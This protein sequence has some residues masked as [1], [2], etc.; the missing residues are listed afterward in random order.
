MITDAKWICCTSDIGTI[1]PDFRKTVSFKKNIKNATAYISA[2]GLYNFFIN[3][4]KVG[5]A[6]LAPGWTVLDKRVQY[7]TY[8]ITDFITE[9]TVFSIMCGE[10]WA[11]GRLGTPLRSVNN[12][13][14]D[15]ISVIAEVVVTYE[16]GSV[17]VIHTDDTWQVYTSEILTSGLYD[18]ETVDTTVTPEFVCNASFDDTVTAKLVEQISELVCERERVA[19]K[20]YFITPKGERVIDFG[21]ELAGYVE[22]KIKGKR[23]D[24][25]V[26]THAEVLDK[27]GNF[28]NDNYRSAKNELVYVLSG[29]EDIFKPSFTFQGY[30]YIRLDEFPFDNVDL[31]CFTSVAIY[32]D[33]K[34]TG[35]FRCGYEKLNQLYSNILW[36]QRSNFI[37]IPTDCPQR[38]ERLGWTGDAQVFCRTASI[39]YNT[40]KFF[41]KWLGDVALNQMEDGAVPGVIPSIKYL[42]NGGRTI[43]AGWGDVATIAPWEIYLAYGNKEM[44]R[45]QYDMMKKWVEYIHNAGDEEFL[46]IGGS[47]YGDWLAMDAGDDIYR[48]ATQ[49][50]LIASA[51]FAYSTSLVIKAGKVLGEDTTYHE[52]LLVNIKKAFHE[53]FMKDGLPAIYPKA[54]AFSTNRPVKGLTQT[55]IVLILKFDIC[56]EDEREY[57][58]KTL[59]K[60][61]RENGNRMTTGFLGTPYILH[62]LSENGYT[63]V[64]YDL[65]LQEQNPSWLFSVNQGATTMWEHWDSIK[66]DGT[67]WSTDM[68]SFNHYAYGAVYDWIFGVSAGIKVCEDGPAYKHVTIEP[69]PE[70]KIGHLECSIEVKGGIL[71]SAWRYTGNDIRYDFTVPAGTIA[72]VTLPSGRTVTLS[73]GKYLFVEKA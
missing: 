73:E 18:G 50:D 8:D 35:Y 70:K 25:I 9:K 30:R 51:Y 48:G 67:F 15:H 63:D 26:I 64:A 17:D 59:V 65:L 42:S 49:T 22:I 44:L 24:R 10:G 12:V 40:E 7:Q 16:D 5:R 31:S 23:G 66:T 11:L 58:A 38:D 45:E 72:D 27:E 69:H 53:A 33:M 29:E 68:N 61:I 60:M 41:R 52:T 55:S 1:S 36:G 20:S 43:S 57:L 13:Y 19:A 4:K 56:Q 6:L 3:G 54:D 46:W 71:A 39:N 37:D 32:T 34:R 14:A 62:V 2:M 21:Q 28:Y 47:H